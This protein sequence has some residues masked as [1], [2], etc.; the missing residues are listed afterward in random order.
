M[1]IPVRHSGRIAFAAL[2]VITLMAALLGVRLV[3]LAQAPPT[4]IDTTTQP[5]FAIGPIDGLT[6][7]WYM[8][9]PVTSIPLGTVAYFYQACPPESVVMWA[10]ADEVDRDAQGSTAMSLLLQPGAHI[11][12]VWVVPAHLGAAEIASQCRLNVQDISVDQI[13]VSPIEVWVDPIEIDEGLPPDELNE[14]TMEYF[15]GLSI[16][17]LRDLGNGQYL[18]SVDRLLHM[19]VEVDPPGFAPLMEW[20]LDGYARDIGSSTTVWSTETGNLMVDVGPLLNPEQIEIE[21]Y[22]VTITSHTSG[23]DI[24][25]EGELVVF[26]AETDP[27]GY[28]DEITWLSSTMY[29]TAEPILGEGPIFIAEFNDTWDFDENGDP[30]QWLGVKADNT[31]F[32]QDEK[33]A[34]VAHIASD[35]I[36]SPPNSAFQFVCPGIA[37]KV[38]CTV[39][40]T[41][42]RKRTFVWLVEKIA[43]DANPNLPQVGELILQPGG[44]NTVDLSVTTTGNVGDTATLK[45]TV[46]V[47]GEQVC[48]ST[49]KIKLSSRAVNV[50]LEC[51]TPGPG[52]LDLFATA[53]CPQ[54]QTHLQCCQMWTNV[55]GAVCTQVLNGA[56]GAA[57]CEAEC[58]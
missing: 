55:L 8:A 38:R 27:P 34:C 6:T 26:I 49:G 58:P 10:G 45:L 50:R 42:T 40:N 35:A 11:V 24:I 51:D 57:L 20:R 15:F 16:A 43:G 19:A 4:A 29:G 28:E 23:E 32:N 1:S 33:V 48:V 52:G 13:T 54:N 21:T 17:A 22:S 9:P 14:V 44:I 46:R 5:T 53:E 18:T 3:V 30:F 31:A 12:S 36:V 25:E 37:Q 56:A 7:S 47:G 2:I 39:K 41:G